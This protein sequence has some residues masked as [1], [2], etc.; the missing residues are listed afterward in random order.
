MSLLRPVFR[1][2]LLLFATSFP[3]YAQDTQFGLPPFGSFED[4]KFDIVNELNLNVLFSIPIL[5]TPGRGAAFRYSISFNNPAFAVAPNPQGFAAWTSVGGWNVYPGERCTSG[6]CIFV[7]NTVLPTLVAKS[8]H[9]QCV[10]GGK[11]QNVAGF[12]GIALTDP[13][14]T[15]HPF[16]KGISAMVVTS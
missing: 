13:D 15:S 4:G 14:G 11:L 12:T 5:S 7:P 2:A 6:T 8:A 1:F 9:E 16:P 10:I 3:L